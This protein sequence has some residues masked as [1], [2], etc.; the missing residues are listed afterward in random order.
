VDAGRL[1]TPR[2]KALPRRAAGIGAAVRQ[3]GRLLALGLLAACARD[4]RD[5]I[6]DLDSPDP[7]TR[8]LAAIALALES[9]GAS[10]PALRVLLDTIDRSDAGLEREAAHALVL[11]GGH[12]VDALIDELVRDPLMTEDR[13]GAI[14]NALVMAGPPAAPV[15]V[16][17]L[18]T[19]ARELAGPLGEILLGI[20]APGAPALAELLDGSPDPAVRRFAAFLL[21]R[22]GP[23]ARAA[24]PAL[25]RAASAEDAELAGMARQALENLRS[26][27]GAA[28]GGPR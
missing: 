5:W 22:L 8:G 11:A 4:D 21:L 25:E 18:G 27:Q 1:R 24:R 10:D 2:P 6:A 9:P 20:G 28:R 19:D 16:R 17:R 13:R 12:H 14:M 3:L 15:V 23:G 7:H 26:S